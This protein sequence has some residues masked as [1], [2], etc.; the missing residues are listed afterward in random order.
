MVR[1]YQSAGGRTPSLTERNGG[2][3]HKKVHKPRRFAVLVRHGRHASDWST[4]TDSRPQRV[5]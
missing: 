5:Q 4:R 1:L 2:I 3:R